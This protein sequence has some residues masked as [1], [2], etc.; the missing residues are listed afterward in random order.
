[1]ALLLSPVAVF[2]APVQCSCVLF[3][4]QELGVN[5][6]NDADKQVPNTSLND[7]RTGDVLLLRYDKTHH[8]ALATS[9]YTEGEAMA[10][11]SYRTRPIS[12]VI[13]ESNFI[14]CRETTRTLSVLDKSIWGVYR[15]V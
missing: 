4:R 11:G 3:L 14:R 12:V 6:R 15:P 1:M 2:A 8:V 10:D 13:R 5:I 9:V 7:L